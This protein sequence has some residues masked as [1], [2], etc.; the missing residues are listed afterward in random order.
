M[1]VSKKRRKKGPQS[2]AGKA[3]PW[4]QAK[5]RNMAMLVAVVVAVVGV[6]V[7]VE[8]AYVD[9]GSHLDVRVPELSTGAAKGAEIF[10]ANCTSCHGAN[11]AGSNL[12]PPL[13]HRYYE[14]NHHGDNAFYAAIRVGVRAH[15]WRYGNMPPVPDVSERDIGLVV[16][17]VRELQKANGIF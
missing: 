5:L 12:G 15:H 7:F 14:P 9:D 11:A 8:Q 13:V 10:A 2:G 3:S 4:G 16:R 1:P 17:Y 6:V